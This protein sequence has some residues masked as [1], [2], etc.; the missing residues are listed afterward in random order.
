M[1]KSTQEWITKGRIVKAEGL[2]AG[3][4]LVKLIQTSKYFVL[5][6]DHCKIKGG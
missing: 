5:M 1:R 3:V 2:M 6:V 4:L